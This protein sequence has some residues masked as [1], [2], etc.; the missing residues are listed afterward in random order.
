LIVSKGLHFKN[1]AKLDSTSK[2]LKEKHIALAKCFS[3]MPRIYL[4]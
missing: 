2:K 3:F 4:R 1:R